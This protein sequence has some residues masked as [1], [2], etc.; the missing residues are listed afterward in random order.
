MKLRFGIRFL[1]FFF[2]SVLALAV[3]ISLVFHSASHFSESVYWLLIIMMILHSRKRLH[4][5]QYNK[6]ASLGNLQDDRCICLL[7]TLRFQIRFQTRNKNL[8][9]LTVCFLIGYFVLNLARNIKLERRLGE[10]VWTPCLCS[11][12]ILAS[13]CTPARGD[14]RLG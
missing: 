12:E 9:K 8:P 10:E 2:V 5:M 6:K 14:A 7:F 3:L 1:K 4:K 11:W 13:I